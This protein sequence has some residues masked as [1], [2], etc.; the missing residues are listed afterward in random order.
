MQSRLPAQ[1]ADT[2]HFNEVTERLMWRWI[3][4][5]LGMEDAQIM[6]TAHIREPALERLWWLADAPLFIDD[7]LVAGFYDAVVRPEFELQGKTIGEINEKANSLLVGGGG[8][9]ELGLPSFLSFGPNV[10]VD[11]K[12]E[13]SRE[14]STQA[15]KAYEWKAVKTAGRGLEE[16]V[17]VYVADQR[18]HDRLLFLDCPPTDI[19]TLAGGRTKFEATD[20]FPRSL[21]FLEV[22]PGAAIIPTMC[23]FSSGGLEPLHAQLI[24]KLWP[25]EEGRPIY[26]SESSPTASVERRGYWKAINERYDSR[27]AMEVLESA[28]KDG[29]KLEWIDFRLSLNSEG[30]TLH[31]HI[32]PRGQY[33]AGTF[34]YNFI[35]RGNRKG[36]R[37]VGSLKRGPDVNVLAIFEC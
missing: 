37:I 22:Q 28:M 3:R 21:V 26:P 15:T 32:C 8:K 23:E 10:K 19:K 17:A 31:L 36:V 4:K 20:S 14:R 16:L 33:S 18:F 30:D 1:P 2:G 12:L 11:A 27:T 35:R 24:S 9:A 25:S 34:G 5:L 13:H 29:R 6:S 7:Q